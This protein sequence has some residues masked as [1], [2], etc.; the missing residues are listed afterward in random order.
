MHVYIMQGMRSDGGIKLNGNFMFV[1]FVNKHDL[2]FLFHYIL[3]FT[4]YNV[5]IFHREPEN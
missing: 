4:L 1:F 3:I 5:D 2:V